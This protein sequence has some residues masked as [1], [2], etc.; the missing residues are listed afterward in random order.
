MMDAGGAGSTGGFMFLDDDMDDS[1]N[2]EDIGD[3]GNEC[4]CEI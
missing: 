3:I 1:G 2:D 4:D